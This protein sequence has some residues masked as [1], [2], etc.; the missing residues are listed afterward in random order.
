MSRFKVLTPLPTERRVST[1]AY[2]IR[3]VMALFLNSSRN[4]VTFIHLNLVTV[5]LQTYLHMKALRA[6]FKHFLFSLT[7]FH[8]KYVQ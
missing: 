3:D 4:G 8:F 2:R 7:Y 6:D 1:L 5:P